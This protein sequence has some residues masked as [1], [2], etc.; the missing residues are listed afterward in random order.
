VLF[1]HGDA[2]ALVPARCAR[3]LHD[4][5]SDAGGRTEFQ[6]LPASGHMLLNFQAAQVGASIAHFM[7]S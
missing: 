5:I 2:D 3:V 1:L 6:L 4:R 7:N